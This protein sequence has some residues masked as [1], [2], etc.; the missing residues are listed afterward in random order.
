LLADWVYVRDLSPAT[1]PQNY[2][3]N[4]NM[5]ETFN[6]TTQAEFLAQDLRAI[7]SPAMMQWSQEV[8][9]QVQVRGERTV[10]RRNI[11]PT[12]KPP[13][14]IDLHYCPIHFRAEG[15][16]EV[17]V[18]ALVHGKR[19]NLNDDALREANRAAVL[20]N[21]TKDTVLLLPGAGTTEGKAADPAQS[22]R[23]SFAGDTGQAQRPAVF[24]N[25]PARRSYSKRENPT[26]GAGGHLAAGQTQQDQI[27]LARV[28]Q[29]CRFG[30]EGERQALQASI[31][32]LG[33]RD[34][35]IVIEGHTPAALSEGGSGPE[36][37]PNLPKH[38]KIR[39]APVT[40]PVTGVLS[41]MVTEHDVSDL[42][43]ALEKLRASREQS[44]KLLYSMVSH[45]A[46]ASKGPW[47]RDSACKEPLTLTP[48][49][50]IH[51]PN[52]ETASCPTTWPTASAR[53]SACS[54]GY[55]PPCRYS[56]Q[57]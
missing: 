46:S 8:C 39:F 7:T 35:P 40:D 56:S 57:T 18:L 10:K 28:L 23:S 36:I 25:L 33:L 2:W 27:T 21:F 53:G 29:T 30:S 50:E 14:V 15:A 12:G 22:E 19:V 44:S 3:A 43:S 20:V 32:R 37:Y 5:L 6:M 26:V 41:V 51:P 48:N 4:E 47:T 54:Q 49:P 17:K 1:G 13:L 16:T 11:Y 34:P 31:L 24:T 55:I 52:P 45:S 9:E 38:R 42:K